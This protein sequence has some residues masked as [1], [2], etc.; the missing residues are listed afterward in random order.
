MVLPLAVSLMALVGVGGPAIDYGMSIQKKSD[1][2]TLAD[3]AALAGASGYALAKSTE[4]QIVATATAF[5]KQKETVDGQVAVDVKTSNA[6]TVEVSLARETTP[7]FGKIFGQSDFTLTASAAAKVVDASKICVLA[8]DTSKSGALSLT[9]D[10]VL[11]ANNCGAYSNSISFTGLSSYKNSAL[12]AS[13]ICSAGGVGGGTSNFN[14]A[15]VQ[16]CPATPDPLAGRPPPPTAGCDYAG[17]EISS[18]TKILSPGVYCGGLLVSGSSHVTFHSGVYVMKDGP[19]EVVKTSTITGENVGFYL[20]GDDAVFLFAGG[21]TVDLTAPTDGP[22]AG[23]LFF[24]D[25][26]NPA[27]R[28]HEIVS[29]NARKLVG[30][31]YLSKGNFAVSS[32]KPITDQSAYTAIVANTIQLNKYPLLVLNTNYD[33]TDVPVPSGLGAKGGSVFLTK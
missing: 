6:E 19:L 5:A 15:P 20:T 30:T 3:G 2:Q 18:E 29:E 8:L 32:K 13:L 24:E 14:P 16:D 4:A 1:L 9:G 25:R 12:N 23:L 22:L 33:L 31:I 26:S 11:Q 28:D 17:W 7:F 27:G 10:A 21:S